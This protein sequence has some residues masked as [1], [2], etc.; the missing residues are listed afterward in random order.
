MATPKEKYYNVLLDT[1]VKDNNPR[2]ESLSN[3]II[4]EA[5]S[6]VMEEMEAE[7]ERNY[8][9]ITCDTS[10]QYP[11]IQKYLLTINDSVYYVSD[12]H[13][14]TISDSSKQVDASNEPIK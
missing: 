12:E 8:N 10:Y 1:L 7:F 6:D 5:V 3:K 9:E 11:I 13:V 2:G 14:D 4:Q